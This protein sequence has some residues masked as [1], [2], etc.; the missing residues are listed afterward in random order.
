MMECSEQ[1]IGSITNFDATL[2]SGGERKVNLC[3]ILH[4]PPLYIG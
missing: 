3:P 2:Q 4:L 1:V